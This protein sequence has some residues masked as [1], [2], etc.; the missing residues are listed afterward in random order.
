MQAGATVNAVMVHI[1]YLYCIV[2][3]DDS[4]KISLK[5]NVVNACANSQWQFELKYL[6]YKQIS[7]CFQASEGERLN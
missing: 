4:K 7:I 5:R 3:L 6:A 1:C 2:F